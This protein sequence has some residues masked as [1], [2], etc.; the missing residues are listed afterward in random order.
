M[1]TM[2]LHATSAVFLLL[3]CSVVSAQDGTISAGKKPPAKDQ[4]AARA[5]V[6]QNF[7]SQQQAQANWNRADPPRESPTEQGPIAQDRQPSKA[8][9]GGRINGQGLPDPKIDYEGEAIE[10]ISPM[11]PEEIRKFDAAMLERAR[12]MSEVPGGPY[13]IKGHRVVRVSFEPNAKPETIDVA[14]NMGAVVTFVDRAGSPLIVDGVKAFSYA[15]EVSVMETDELKAKGGSSSLEITPK[16]LTGHGTM[17]VRLSGVQTPLLLQVRVGDSSKQVD[18]LVQAVVPVL[19]PSKTVLPGDRLEADTG[20]QVAEMQ[21]FLMGI[22]PAGA[23]DVQ[24]RQVSGTIVWLWHNHLYVRTPHTIFSPG[25][26]Q[27]QSAVDG[28]AVYEM[29]LTSVVRMGVDGREV[30]AVFD[31]PYIPAV[32][33]AKKK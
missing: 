5:P 15:F 8:K 33:G 19:T 26:F 14:L 32:A 7:P 12:A 3:M 31:L 29:P 11:T 16:S 17:M 9:G 22:P 13:T 30:E 18:S 21:G 27:R 20:L 6:V 23:V 10:R 1:K 28:T 24:V 25:W 2:R 4:Q